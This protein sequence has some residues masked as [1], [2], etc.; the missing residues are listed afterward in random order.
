MGTKVRVLSFAL[1]LLAGASVA[2]GADA[3]PSGS[4]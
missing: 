4:Y 3:T 2:T 1:A